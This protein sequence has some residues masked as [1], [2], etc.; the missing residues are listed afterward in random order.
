MMVSKI[1]MARI[2]ILKR[3]SNAGAGLTLCVNV[4]TLLSQNENLANKFKAHLSSK[5]TSLFSALIISGSYNG[6]TSVTLVQLDPI[7][8]TV[9]TNCSL[10]R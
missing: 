6:V 7:S 1:L 4:D 3:N 8:G 10:P 9:V 2:I 5:V